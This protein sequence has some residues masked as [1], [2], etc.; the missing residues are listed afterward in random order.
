MDTNDVKNLAASLAKLDPKTKAPTSARALDGWIAQARDSLD[1]YGPRLGWLVAA[2]VVTAALQRAVDEDGRSLFLVKGGTMLQYRLPGMAR[3]TRDIDGL[4]RGDLDE[5]LRKLDAT[6]AE[7]WG[8]LVMKRSEVEQI[9]V[10]ERIVNPRRFDVKVTLRGVTWRRVQVEISHDEGGAGARPEEIPSPSLAGFG[11]PTPDRLISLSMAYQIAQK[12]HASS[13]PHDPPRRVNDR[14]RD[15]VDL[16]LLRDLATRTG[17]P[18]LEEVRSAVNDI[19]TARAAEAEG[20]GIPA[21]AWP[22]TLTAHPHWH[23]SYADAAASVG[24]TLGLEEAVA[25]LNEWLLLMC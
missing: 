24:V 11:L 6:L 21:R 9:H 12:I 16:V 2:T 7:P 14:A 23:Q 17:H 15:V 10:P 22:V 13:D 18:A 3:T 4:V 8:P 19:F 25:E 20:A 5:F 1:S